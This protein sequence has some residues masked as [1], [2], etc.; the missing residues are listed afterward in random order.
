MLDAA[1]LNYLAEAIIPLRLSCIRPDGWPLVLSLWFIPLDG[2]LYCATQKPAKVVTY[3]NL[4]PK[5]GFEVASDLPPYCGVR[6]LAE[7]EI[8]PAQGPEILAL[9]LQR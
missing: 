3:L 4:N 1:V 5:C 2:H 6:G 8:I 7:A 9:L